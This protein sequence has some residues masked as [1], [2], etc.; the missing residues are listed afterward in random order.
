MTAQQDITRLDGRLERIETGI[1]ALTTRIGEVHTSIEIINTRCG[2]CWPVVMGNAKQQPVNV[3]LAE[4][5]QVSGWRSKK[6]WFLLG[7]VP[8]LIAAIV[9]AVVAICF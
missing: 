5:E 3:R 9:G 7:A 6:F 4:L 2:V 8:T 1:R